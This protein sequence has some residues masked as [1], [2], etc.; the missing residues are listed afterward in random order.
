MSHLVG[1]DDPAAIRKAN[2]GQYS[3]TV[4]S[5]SI[6][7]QSIYDVVFATGN[8]FLLEFRIDI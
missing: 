6:F 2:W 7:I 5:C 4:P 1:L 3:S 8:F